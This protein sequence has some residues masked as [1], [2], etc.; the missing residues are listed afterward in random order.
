MLRCW[1]KGGL[2]NPRE[3]GKTDSPSQIEASAAASSDNGLTPREGLVADAAGVL[4][5]TGRFVTYTVGGL[6]DFGK[7]LYQSADF[8]L[9]GD[10]T[11]RAGYTSV[12]PRPSKAPRA[13]FPTVTTPTPMLPPA[14]KNTFRDSRPMPPEAT[15]SSPPRKT[16]RSVMMRPA[17]MKRAR[18]CRKGS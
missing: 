9:T 14:M 11:S 6:F 13:L 17:T 2:G 12:P 18:C 7:T 5:G 16:G 3:T 4:A 15:P 10:E 8:L 1:Q